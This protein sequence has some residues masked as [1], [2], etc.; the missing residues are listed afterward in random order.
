M[1]II[2]D[3]TGRDAQ[4][5][6]AIYAP[7]VTGSAISFELEPPGAAE[8]AGRIA[9]AGERHAWLVLEDGGRVVGFAYGQEFR[10][11]PAYRWACETSIY[12]EAGRR[13]TGGGRALYAA[14]LERLAGRGYRRAFAGMTLP[15]PASAGLHRALGFEPV[16]VYRQVGWKHGAWHDVAWVQLALATGQ[17]PPAEPR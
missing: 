7:Y 16:G 11:R 6:A 1:P 9:A 17:D 4:A 12:L 15:N 8:M 2:R 13:R 3:A 14:L 5:C 10:E